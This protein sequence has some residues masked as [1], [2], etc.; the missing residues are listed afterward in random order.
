MNQKDKL[1]LQRLHNMALKNILQVNRITST[2][3]IHDTNQ[4]P[5]VD[6]RRAIHGC[7]IMH[8]VE[9]KMH[10]LIYWQNIIE[11]KISQ[12]Q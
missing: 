10:Q 2:A 7:E 9:Y 12:T 6:V 11:E 4:M 3:E 1:L 5:M 8:K